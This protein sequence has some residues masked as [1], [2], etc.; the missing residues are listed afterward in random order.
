MILM[1]NMK[2][3][4]ENKRKKRTGKQDGKNEMENRTENGME[5]RT[6]NGTENGTENR[7]EQNEEKKSSEK[8]QDFCRADFPFQDFCRA[9]FPFQNFCRADFLFKNFCRAGFPFQDLFRA[10]FLFRF[11]RA[12]FPFVMIVT[13]SGFCS[14]RQP[15]SSLYPAL[16]A[17][18][19]IS[20]ASA[21]A[22]WRRSFRISKTRLLMISARKMTRAMR[23]RNRL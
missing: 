15:S 21:A 19:F 9:D 5:N 13:V 3:G 23:Q 16:S 14:G 22:T 10:G 18:F 7:T 12:P 17:A 20:S 6:E 8:F 11:I 1:K 2:T 4:R